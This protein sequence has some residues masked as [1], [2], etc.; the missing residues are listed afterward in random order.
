MGGVL[1]II[2]NFDVKMIIEN[3]FV[4]KYEDIN[5]GEMYKKINGELNKK[6][7]K[8]IFAKSGDALKIGEN[9]SV[10][11]Y[12]P[13]LRRNINDDSLVIKIFSEGDGTAIFTGDVCEKKFIE[14]L[15]KYK[16]LHNCDV[17]KFPHHGIGYT[18]LILE[19]I[20]SEYIVVPNNVNSRLKNFINEI[21]LKSKI[22]VTGE[23]DYY[24]F[25]EVN[26]K[27]EMVR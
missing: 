23:V 15:E 5:E 11:F 26:G 27:F 6:G 7:I 18:N 2:K 24:Q 16:D 10:L 9:V 12:N 25:E 4:K 13:E 8:R 3:E 1:N 20:S 17:L 19:T 22:Y 21:E 14:L